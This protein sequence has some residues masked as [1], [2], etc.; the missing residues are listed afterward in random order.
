MSFVV[1]LGTALTLLGA[2]D[3][4]GGHGAG[5]RRDRRGP[6]RSG[7]GSA[8]RLALDSVRPLLGALLIASVV[9]AL[10]FTTVFLLPVAIWLA[11]RWALIAPV[12]ELESAV[13]RSSAL[14]RSGR[15]VRHGWF[16]VGSLAVVGAALAL[17]AGPLAR[18]RC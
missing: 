16:K 6:P 1:A 9:L 13:A 10:L 7:R 5:A 3:R 14:R 11:V 15:L 4:A 17:I 12:V 8:F 18:A 2:R